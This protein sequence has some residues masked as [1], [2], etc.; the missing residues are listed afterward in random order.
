MARPF[1]FRHHVIDFLYTF[2]R[3]GGHYVCVGVQ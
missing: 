3:I 1:P 2:T